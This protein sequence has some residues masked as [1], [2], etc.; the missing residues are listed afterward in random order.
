MDFVVLPD[1]PAA[2]AV[3]EPLTRDP[4]VRVVRHSSGRPWLVG[5]WADEELTL[6]SSGTRRLAVL[7]RSTADGRRLEHM[8][9]RARTPDQ[10]DDVARSLPGCFHLVASFGGWT[11]AQGS[12]STAR[13]IFF[14]DVAGTTVA[15]DGPRRL[16]QW[17]HPGRD[18]APA[19]DRDLLALRLLTPVPPWPLSLRPVWSGVSA[20]GVGCRLD[21][22]PAGT[23]RQ[24]R[25]WRPPEPDTPPGQAAEHLRRALL[26]CVAARTRAPLSADLSGGLDSTTL[27]FLADAAGADLL[28][29]HWTPADRANDDTRWAEYAARRLPAARHHV[30]AG[31][32]GPTWYETT[33]TADGG[34]EEGPLP[35]AR[36]R[37][38]MRRL[39]SLVAHHGSRCH[40]LG[41]GG[42]ELFGV[43]PT[44]LWSLIRSHPLSSLPR[45]HRFRAL[46]RW[47]LTS[48]VRG[49]ADGASFAAWLR[50]T[51]DRLTAPAPGPGDAL[52][53]WG[54][55]PR[56]PPWATAD[57]IDA[58][59]RL[60]R[61]TAEQERPHPHHRDRAQ[62][63]TL[64]IVVQSGSALRQLNAALDDAGVTCEAPFLDDRV[65]EAAL[66]VR[67]EDRLVS[68]D[69]KPMLRRAVRGIVPQEILARRSKGEFSAEAFQGM[70]RNRGDLLDLCDDLHLSRLGL[71]DPDA[72]RTA[73]LGP[74]TQSRQLVPYENT[75]ACESWLRSVAAPAPGTASLAGET[76]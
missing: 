10:L 65:V 9:A 25:W 11:R 43:L 7:G 40:L 34:H 28:T 14:A 38:H 67:I 63:Q 23:A 56:L 70:R 51:A 55:E 19:V 39:L 45:I 73:L 37:A 48:T 24:V 61:D 16:A 71:V 64:D 52:L 62:H 6:V 30:T 26:A 68:G 2:P 18:D 58:V 3:A 22:S 21:L 13:Q 12:L 72:L 29:H 54:W 33:A 42:D 59:R 8:L 35:W 60:L 69:F 15:A 50:S 44:A 4:A 32:D 31:Q 75:L 20:L 1:S 76:P 41:V 17:T 27:C 46:N 53:G 5:R 47:T 74:K 57:A 66:T 49:L 36:N